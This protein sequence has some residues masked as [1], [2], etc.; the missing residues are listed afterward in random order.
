MESGRSGRTAG[1]SGA[2]GSHSSGC[3]PASAAARANAA[4][5][6]AGSGGPAGDQG[7]GSCWA[8]MAAG[9][10]TAAEAEAERPL[11]LPAGSAGR[12]S[13]WALCASL[14]SC[15]CFCCLAGR[16]WSCDCSMVSSAAGAAGAAGAAPSWTSRRWRRC[17]WRSR[18]SRQLRCMPQNTLRS[19]KRPHC[20]QGEGGGW[21]VVERMQ[22]KE[23]G[24]RCVQGSGC[25][26]KYRRWQGEG[27]SGADTSILRLRGIH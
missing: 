3:W 17:W 27:T 8:G 23:V 25:W 6:A 9:R 5:R 12:S 24:C 11:L 26:C 13:A 14:G 22:C 2:T 18:L 16:Q 7:G 19:W 15:C 21:Q 1:V 4:A 20:E 10:L